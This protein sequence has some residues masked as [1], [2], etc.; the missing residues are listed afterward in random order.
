MGIVLENYFTKEF[1]EL[2]S[3]SIALISVS[4][5]YLHQQRAKA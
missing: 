3:I 1:N 5:Y 4:L 2:V